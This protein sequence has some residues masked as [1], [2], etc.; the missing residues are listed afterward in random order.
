[1]LRNG[2]EEAKTRFILQ[3]AKSSVIV[4]GRTGL[5]SIAGEGGD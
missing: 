2:V 4:I 5:K 1:M 3:K